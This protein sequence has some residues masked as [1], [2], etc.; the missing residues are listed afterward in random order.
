MKKIAIFFVLLLTVLPISAQ[1]VD[2]LSKEVGFILVGRFRAYT[3]NN[4]LGFTYDISHSV[5]VISIP[6]F[7]RHDL[8]ISLNEGPGLRTLKYLRIEEQDWDAFEQQ[9]AIV[10]EKFEKWS[11]VAAMNNEKDFIK[12]IPANF[13]NVGYYSVGLV[14]EYVNTD[15]YAVFEVEDGRC[16][17]K[18]SDSEDLNKSSFILYFSYET[19]HNLCELIKK[20]NAMRNLDLVLKAIEQEKL[21]EQAHDALYD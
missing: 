20:E 3:F 11:Q 17:L 8:L 14:N 9:M 7:G 18:L 10:D 5:R 4:V 13:E 19:F 16:T 15:L 2:E 6:T 12:T 1:E 21:Q